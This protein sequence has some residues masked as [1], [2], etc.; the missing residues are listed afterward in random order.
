VEAIVSFSVNTKALVGLPLALDRRRT[1]LGAARSYL[2]ANTA[3]KTF[4]LA[5]IN[6]VHERVITQIDIYLSDLVAR[7]AQPDAQ[8]IRTVIGSYRASD[9]RAATRADATILNLPSDLPHLRPL[10][11]A[12]RGYDASAF[13]DRHEPVEALVP[14]ADHHADM[15]Y[16]P[17]WTDLLSPTSMGRDVIWRLT[18][19]LAHAGLLQ[20]P[21]D[22]LD[23]FVRP[24][25]GDWAGLL[26]CADVFTHLGAMLPAASTCVTDSAALIP[27]VWT[28]NVAGMCI[29]NLDA[30]ASSLANG[31]A[32]LADLSTAYREVARGVYDNA[33]LLEAAITSMIDLAAD[34]V[35]EGL[36]S[37]ILELWS[38]G[39]QV[40]DFIRLVSTAIRIVNKA[41]DVVGAWR[42]GAGSTANRLGVLSPIGPLSAV[43]SPPPPILLPA[44]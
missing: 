22:P 9:L 15:P 13:D 27:L 32:P 16:Q 39:T 29:V 35:I 30:F 23:T 43:V 7:Y 25:V 24:F 18:S 42:N 26:R 40:R 2:T 19:T 44:G 8:R 38:V 1:D 36:G 12:G 41:L 28:G 20:R 17:S 6:G 37:G 21:I 33:S 3:I 10:T 11:A 31:F 34:V 4:G 14:P 5:D